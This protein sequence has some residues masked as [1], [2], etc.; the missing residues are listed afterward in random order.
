ML[1]PGEEKKAM[2]PLLGKLYVTANSSVDKLMTAKD[3]A[4][5]AI[6]MNIVNDAS[7]RN[8]LNKFHTAVVK[9]IGESTV[10]NKPVD[11]GT[12]VNIARETKMVVGDSTIIPAELPTGVVKTESIPEGQDSLLDQ[13]LEDDDDDDE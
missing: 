6:E 2:L 3:L 9:V 11:E 12:T 7:S 4:A 1:F 8:G 5:E 13:L 10:D